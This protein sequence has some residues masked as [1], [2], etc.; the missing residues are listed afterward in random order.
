M[1]FSGKNVFITGGASGMGKATA[2][3]LL[4]EGARVAILDQT[5][6]APEFADHADSVLSL[7]GDASDAAVLRDALSTLNTRFGRLDLAVNAAGIHGKHARILDHEDAAMDRL[8]DVNVR[9]IFLAMKYEAQMMRQG[10]GAIVNFA[11]VFSQ[12]SMATLVLYGAT[13]HAVVGLTEGA[14]VEF[15]EHG[16]RVNAVSPGPIYTPFL[17]KLSPEMEASVNRSI[18]QARIGRPEEVA[19]AV[20]WLL[21]SQASY[22]TG[23]NFIIDGGQSVKLGG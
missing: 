22:V 20:A 15:A 21:S 2:Q 12:G 16:I 18:P 11:S 23:A 4:A 13:K 17:G 9:G 5:D 1:R 8:L 3:L 10:G 14:A 7:T 6:A 19:G